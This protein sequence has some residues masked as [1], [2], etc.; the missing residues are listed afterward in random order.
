V[1]SS[2]LWSGGAGAIVR[3]GG[4]GSGG[5]LKSLVGVADDE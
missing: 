1:D 4:D 2:D 5:C 3:T